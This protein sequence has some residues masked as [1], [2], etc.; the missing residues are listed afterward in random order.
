MSRAL[1]IVAVSSLALLL[2][3]WTLT[4]EPAAPA[5]ADD[6]PGYTDTPF[7]PGGQWRVHDANRPEPA[8]VW[9]SPGGV[10]SDAV[11]LFDGSDLSAWTSRGGDA[12]W[13]IVDGAAQVNGTGDIETREHFGD[14]QLH[15]EWAAPPEVKSQSQGRGNSGVFLMGQYEIQVLDSFNNR[16]Y[17]DGQAAS[18]YGQYPPD[19]NAC[20]G[21]GRWQTYDILFRAPRFDGTE[22]QSPAQVTLLHNGI[23]VQHARDFLGKTSH[24]KVAGYAAHAATGPIKLQ[25]HGN[26]VRFRNIWVRQLDSE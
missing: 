8:V 17:S 23:V 25:D 7:L 26:P 18:M 10:P 5:V 16:T 1:S 14:M 2:V 6:P 9:T 24:K 4:P 3:A 19:V 13:A 20:R 22:L 12:G 21:P 11:V 15:I